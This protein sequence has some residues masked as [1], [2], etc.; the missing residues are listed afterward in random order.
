MTKRTLSAILAAACLAGAIGL[1]GCKK[2]PQAP[3]AEQQWYR[4]ISA[5]TSGTIFRRSPVRVLFVENAGTPGPAAAGLFVFTP[6][7]EGTAVWAGPRELVFKPK[8]ELKG[9]QEYRAV[10]NVGRILDLPKAYARFEFKFG[11]V[12][13]D[14][15]VVLEGLFAEDP[16]KPQAQVL[17]GRV[18]TSDM[19][20][21]TLVEKVLEAEQEGR[22]L[23]IEW[24][25]ALEGLTHYFTV[26]DVVRKEE[27]S[28]VT[29]SWDGA[30][31][32]ISN[33]GRRD[34]EVPAL[35][36]FEVVSIEPVLGETR[37]I[38]VRFS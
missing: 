17:R 2:K 16:E 7:I 12:R 10:L 21:K 37:H 34:V 19:E 18:T 15:E 4:Y 30:P 28:A 36:A 3:A 14:L 6:P 29:L 35:G 11:V 22:T 26:K 33:R 24:S 5:F 23:A 31:I 8:G 20:E 32:R 13:P 1:A 9:G 38:L 25:H 27:A